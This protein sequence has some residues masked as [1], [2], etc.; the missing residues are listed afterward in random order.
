[1]ALTKVS[2]GLLSTG[3]VDNSNATAITLNSDESATFAGNVGVGTTPADA[4][5][6]LAASGNAYA[7]IARGT[8]S[9]GEVGLRLRGGTSGN[10][11]Y[12]YQKPSSDNLNFY[13]TSD[14]MILTSD[15]SLL[16]GKTA[17]GVGN[18]G[19][20]A[21]A[22]TGGSVEMA[23]D[24]GTVLYVNR[25][26]SDGQ[27]LSLRK[28]NTEVGSIGTANSGDLFIGNDDTSLLF[29][30]GSDAILPRGTAG[31]ARSGDISLGLS[32]HRFKNLYLS[33]GIDFNGSSG[34]IGTANRSFLMDEY[35]IGTCTI[36]FSASGGGTTLSRTDN[37]TAYY[38]KTGNICTVQYY[39][40]GLT[41]TN[42]G[43]GSARIHGLP[44]N[45]R[46]GTYNYGVASIT[47]ANATTTDIQNGFTAPN[48]SHITVMQR[49][50]SSGAT[51]Q[52]GGVRY[53]MFSVTYLTN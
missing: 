15:G 7:S 23:R 37:V 12:V 1:M 52:T 50:S 51:W 22:D 47:H 17:L 4:L 19:F 21:R 6:V 28:D 27:L 11:W 3:I 40:G 39:S 43:S 30:G 20:A 16:V 36:S 13:N 8:Q 34:G 38:Q 42:A 25:G 46:G 24:G 9:Q 44:F 26:T 41:F 48:L 31:A 10:D 33:G 35:E 32:S 53:L 5:H 14:R 2:R 49:Y 45:S 18:Y 29:A